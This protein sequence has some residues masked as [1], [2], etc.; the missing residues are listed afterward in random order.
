M[1]RWLSRYVKQ[2]NV[3]GI[4]I[5][6]REI[7]EQEA[8]P[9]LARTPIPDVAREP[10]VTAV[11]PSPLVQRQ[12]YLCV[13]G[14]SASSQ[15]SPRELDLMLDGAEIEFHIHSPGASQTRVWVAR[16]ALQEAL[17]RWKAAGSVGPITIVARTARK[18]AEV[19]V[20]AEPEGEVEVQAGWW[21]W[22]P[23][24]DVKAALEALGV[25]VPWQ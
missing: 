7:S 24:E 10:P 4:G 15:R 6:L 17:D 13:S 12:D 22:V 16:D 19:V 1:F 21:I 23:R 3:Y 5:E 8:L 18:Q 11:V 9:L 25:R 20:V 14:V 2:I